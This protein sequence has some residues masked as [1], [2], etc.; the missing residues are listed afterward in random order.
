MCLSVMRDFQLRVLSF[1]RKVCCYYSHLDGV[2]FVH[3]FN[4]TKIAFV[5]LAK[6]GWNVFCLNKVVTK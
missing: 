1:L 6:L 5:A 3:F 4:S 2:I